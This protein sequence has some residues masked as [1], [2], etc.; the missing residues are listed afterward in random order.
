[1]PALQGLER[2]CRLEE[3]FNDLV[4]VLE[5]QAAAA[6]EDDARVEILIRLADLHERHFVRPT[7]AAPVL[8]DA[9]RI[10]PRHPA[11][12]SALERCYH[13]LR[14]WPE[15]VRV[16]ELRATL[17]D[18]TAEQ[19]AVLARSAE[20]LELEL[21][22]LSG[23]TQAWQR[24]WDLDPT[25]ERAV[26]ELAR[27]AE[28]ANDWAAAAAYKAKL[29]ELATSPEVAAKIH[30]AIA[31]MLSAPDRD[32]KLARIHYERAASIHPN[33][34]EAWEGPERDARRAGDPK[35][36]A[37]F[38]EKRAASTEAPRPKAQLFVELAQLHASQGDGSVADLAFERAIK[39]DAT[40]EIA[41][42]AVLDRPRPRG[43]LGRG[44]TDVR[45]PPRR[46]PARG[47]PGARVR[48]LPARDPNCVRARARGPRVPLCA[49]RLPHVSVARIRG[50][51]GRCL[52]RGPRRRGA[53]RPASG[54]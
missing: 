5:L 52:S 48:S 23:A 43:A 18:S 1:M 28:R 29:A 7:Q 17:A 20:I 8:E 9:L 47:E 3:R 44:A 26:S 41:A 12:L 42:E 40:N 39:A 33:T 19:S 45:R 15:L 13:S 35:R 30:V 32:P 38:L 51:P 36:V 24:V 11:A 6:D 16:L 21:G 14:A 10:N 25:S 54:S 53:P 22:D 27:F 4:G 49:R 2:I 31:E 46:D 34:T 37:M 50:G